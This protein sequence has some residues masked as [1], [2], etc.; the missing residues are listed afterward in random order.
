MKEILMNQGNRLRF[1]VN[2]AVNNLCNELVDTAVEKGKNALKEHFGTSVILYAGQQNYY[3]ALRYIYDLDKEKYKKHSGS[4]P[5][6]T[7]VYDWAP[8]ELKMGAE[9]FIN[10]DGT[11]LFIKVMRHREFDK[12]SAIDES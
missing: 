3:V 9:C 10:L 6:F 1:S 5:G 2:R 4:A 8:H 12:Y 7:R 11:F